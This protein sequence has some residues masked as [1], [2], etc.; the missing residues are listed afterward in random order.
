[1]RKGKN[2]FIWI[3]FS[4]QKLL[5]KKVCIYSVS[6]SVRDFGGILTSVLIFLCK[7]RAYG[8]FVDQ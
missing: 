6:L 7:V 3:F 8:C 4:I 1:M 5:R 2:I